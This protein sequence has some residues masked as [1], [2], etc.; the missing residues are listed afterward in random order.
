M[1]IKNICKQGHKKTKEKY[2]REIKIVY[3]DFRIR[4]IFSTETSLKKSCYFPASKIL[5]KIKLNPK[6]KKKKKNELTPSRDSHKFLTYKI[7]LG[8]N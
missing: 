1:R 4:R 7:K 5:I 3:Y 8:K 2:K 6:Q